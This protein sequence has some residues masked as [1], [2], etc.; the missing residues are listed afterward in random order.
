MHHIYKLC[1]LYKTYL[2]SNICSTFIVLVN[3][4]PNPGHCIISLLF[5]ISLVVTIGGPATFLPFLPFLP[6]FFL[7]FFPAI[8]KLEELY[9]QNQLKLVPNVVPQTE[10]TEHCVPIETN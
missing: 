10:L 3:A 2:T 4:S 1:K 5:N 6:P 7:P 9:N 8:K